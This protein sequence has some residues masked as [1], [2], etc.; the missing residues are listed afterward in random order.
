M[1]WRDPDGQVS[2][3]ALSLVAGIVVVLALLAAWV[4]VRL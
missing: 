3:A 1:M 4:S 2:Y